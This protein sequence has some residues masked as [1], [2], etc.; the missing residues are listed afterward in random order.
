MP[1]DSSGFVLVG[2][3]ALFVGAA[4]VPIAAMIMVSEMTGNYNLLVPL[5]LACSISYIITGGRTIY[6]NQVLTRAHSPAHREEFIIDVLE[7]VPVEKVMSKS[8]V[9]V[10]PDTTIKELSK[11][12][13]STGH[14]GYPV[15][16]DGRLVGMVTH[17]DVLRIPWSETSKIKV[18]QVMSRGLVTATPNESLASAL[19]RMDEHGVGRLPVVKREDPKKLIGILTRR[20][21]IKGHEMAKHE[22]LVEFRRDVLDKVKVEEI[23]RRDV[24]AVD[25]D[26]KIAELMGLMTKY[27]YQGYPVIE[28]GKLVGIITFD[29]IIKNLKRPETLVRDVA[30]KHLI[31]TYPDETVHQALDRM[32]KYNVGR[33]PVV[34]RRNPTKLLGIIT[35]TDVIRAHE[36]EHFIP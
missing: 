3:A 19:R 32:Y 27:T 33:L 23:M 16:K 14:L 30:N 10:S 12:V 18:E 1:I 25:S 15:V 31:V 9:T 5:M 26:M 13:A 35:K 8:V 11:L 36:L 21:L 34:D 22:G 2:M 24:I 6:E 20:D 28:E 17:R 7:E 4:K 29:E